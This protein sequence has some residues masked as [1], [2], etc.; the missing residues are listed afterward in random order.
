MLEITNDP[1]DATAQGN[2][3]RLSRAQHLMA[4]RQG[5]LPVWIRAPKT[6]QEFFSGCSRAK[7]YDWASKGFIRSVSIREPGQVKG[8][9]LFHLQSLLSFIERCEGDQSKAHRTSDPV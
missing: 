7:L 5:A 3:L 2:T 8:C 9:R 4:E 6:G 1:P